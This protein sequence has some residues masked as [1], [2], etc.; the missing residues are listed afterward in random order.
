MSVI[1]EIPY[2]TMDV[3]DCNPLAKKEKNKE[4]KTEYHRLIFFSSTIL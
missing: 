1:G 4:K 3:L 2:L